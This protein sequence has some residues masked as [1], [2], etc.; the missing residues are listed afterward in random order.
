M[1]RLIFILLKIAEVSLLPI[2]YVL[3]GYIGW[4][5]LEYCRYLSNGGDIIEYPHNFGI[6]FAFVGFALSFL[7]FAVIKVI[8]LT[9]VFIPDLFN[10]WIYLNKEW[11]QN[12]V[13]WLK[14]IKEQ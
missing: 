6:L 1:K 10:Y 13:N 2:A 4:F 11:S 9:A 14:R 5:F 3:F 12:I 8:T 7:V